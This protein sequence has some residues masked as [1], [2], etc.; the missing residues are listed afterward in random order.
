MKKYFAI[1]LLCLVSSCQ[2]IEEVSRPEDLIPPEK[3]VDVLTEA[4]LLHGA[5]TY[6][7][8]MMES[9]GIRLE[10]YLWEKYDIDSVQLLRSNAYYGQRYDLY[11]QIY[12]SV[13]IRLERLMVLYD[14]IREREERK[15]D[16]IRAIELKDSLD[17][18][19]DSL[20]AP[21]SQ[22]ASGRLDKN[23]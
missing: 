19:R 18:V 3:M 12:D 9:K 11:K 21:V 6:N 23:R 22:K 15:R 13:K 7:R 20:I 10:E 16:S 17:A 2:D 4:A 5:R 14:T 1:I 8:D